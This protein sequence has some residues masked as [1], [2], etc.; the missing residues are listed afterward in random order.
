MPGG[1]SPL[2]S[3]GLVAIT[4]GLFGC[5][6]TAGDDYAVR[7]ESGSGAQGGTSSG[8]GGAAG[9]AM[10]GAGGA[11]A[12]S[13][14]GG[15]CVDLD[16]ACTDSSCFEDAGLVARYFIDEAAT[17]QS[18]T[19][20]EDS[21][22]SPQALGIEYDA[23]LGFTEVD[24]H[25]GLRWNAAS[26]E[27]KASLLVDGSKIAS[28]LDGQTAATIEIVLALEDVD[29]L[30]SRILHV[31]TGT[32]NG[33]FSLVSDNTSILRFTMNNNPVQSWFYE[34]QSGTRRVVHMVLDTTQANQNDRA[35]L[36]VDGAPAMI[37]A[38]NPPGQGAT[39]DLGTGKTFLLGNRDIG[40]RSFRGT[41]FYAALYARP[42]SSEEA[43][44]HAAILGRSDDR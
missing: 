4:I 5:P 30:S 11:G 18:V 12:S 3:C 20:L 22:S 16:A 33:R 29:N 28:M 1:R 35:K 43:A 26:N 38:N 42:L 15:C 19:R 14:G 39:I 2:R 44:L 41:L 13:N 32:E 24:G 17:G 31:G 6:L 7:S 10:G 37:N 27:G 21:A 8:G 9:G 25:R 34:G 23:N 36:Y 40:G